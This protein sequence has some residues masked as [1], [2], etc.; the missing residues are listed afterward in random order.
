[1]TEPEPAPERLAYGTA[2]RDAIAAAGFNQKTFATK[3]ALISPSHLSMITTGRRLPTP[4]DAERFADLLGEHAAG[5]RASYDEASARPTPRFDANGLPVELVALLKTVRHYMDDLPMQLRG[6]KRLSLASLY[7]R[8]SV[9]MPVE[10]TVV[11]VREDSDEPGLVEEIRRSSILAEPF[12]EVFGRHDHLVIEGA[13][14]LGK[15]TLGRHLVAESINALLG[16][17]SDDPVIPLLLPARVL[18]P[19]VDITWAEALR[20]A[21]IR[22]YG[23]FAD[24]D[25]S[26][27]HFRAGVPGARWLIVVDALDEI[28]SFED[29]EKLL[30][31]IERRM[32]NADAERFVV[33]TRPLSPGETARLRAAGFYELQPF[34]R[35]A[36]EQFAQHWFNPGNT[37]DGALAAAEF[38][39]QIGAA[40][41]GEILVV[42]LLASIAAYVHELDRSRPLP[43]SRY[44]LYERYITKLAD[45]R[46]SQAASALTDLATALGGTDTA[47][48]LEE[49]RAALT[50]RMA[51]AYTARETSL[52]DVAR[53]FIADHGRTVP[54]DD[55]W[56]ELLAEWLSHTGLLG[57]QG[58]RLKFL[59][60][61]FAEHLAATAAARLLPE[62][63]DS[64]ESQFA[65][66]IHRLLADD[67]DAERILVH[68]LHRNS[69]DHA[70]LTH[71]QHGTRNQ[72]EAACRLLCHGVPSTSTHLDD[73]IRLAEQRIAAGAWDSDQVA[74]LS[75]L[76]RFEVVRDRLSRLVTESSID[77]EIKIVLI[78][79]L[80]ES[81]PEI[82]SGAPDLLRRW[83]DGRFYGNIRIKA[84]STLA[85]LGPGHR[86]AAADILEE[87]AESRTGFESA[88]RDAAEALAVLGHDCRERAA[89]VLL[90]VATD[91]TISSWTRHGA[92]VALSR[93]GPVHRERAA[94]LLSDQASD[95]T[96][97]IV[98]RRDSAAALAAFGGRYRTQACDLFTDI[99]GHTNAVQAALT[100]A[101]H[102]AVDPD[103]RPRAGD[104]LVGLAA[105]PN[106]RPDEV[107]SLG[108]ALVELGGEH[109]SQ[110]VGLLISVIN[111]PGIDEISHQDIV[112][113]LLNISRKHRSSVLDQLLDA[114]RQATTRTHIPDV[115]ART[116]ELLAVLSS[117]DRGL[118]AA[119][120][121]S[122][123][124]DPTLHVRGRRQSA[125]SLANLG[126]EHLAQV[127][128][129]L[130]R[131]LSTTASSRRDRV[132]AA[133]L[134]AVLDP[135]RTSL[136]VALIR[137]IGTDATTGVEDRETILWVLEDIVE[138][139]GTELAELVEQYAS[140][141]SVATESRLQPIQRLW[142]LGGVYQA[143]ALAIIDEAMSDPTTDMW[144]L[145][146][147]VDVLSGHADEERPELARSLLAKRCAT[148]DFLNFEELHS[149]VRMVERADSTR[150]LV[151]GLLTALLTEPL[152]ADFDRLQAAE[153]LATL[154]GDHVAS[155]AEALWQLTIDASTEIDLRQHALAVL[156]TLAPDRQAELAT[157][158]LGIAD[159]PNTILQERALSHAV[160]ASVVPEHETTAVEQLHAV[161]TDSQSTLAEQE[162]VVRVIAG[163]G[164]NYLD[165]AL[166][167]WICQL[168]SRPLTLEHRATLASSLAS[169]GYHHRARALQVLVEAVRH[170]DVHV[171]AKARFAQQLVNFRDP[172]R[173]A[174]LKALV[175]I[176][177]QHEV[178]AALRLHAGTALIAPATRQATQS[179]RDLASDRDIDA[180]ERVLA[181][182]SLSKLGQEAREAAITVLVSVMSDRVV[183]PWAR[184]RAAVALSTLGPRAR[185][186]LTEPLIAFTRERSEGDNAARL[187]A[188]GV[189]PELK[190]GLLHDATD[191]MATAAAGTG[192]STWERLHVAHAMLRMGRH[193]IGQAARALHT[194]ASDQQVRIWERRQ[195]LE[196]LG[197]LG[198]DNRLL[199]TELLRDMIATDRAD[200]WERVEVIAAFRYLGDDVERDATALLLALLDDAGTAPAERRH[201]AAT[202]LRLTD[203]ARVR[204]RSV[205]LGMASDHDAGSAERLSAAEALW[206][207]DGDEATMAALAVDPT[208][209]TLTR[210]AAAAALAGGR[211]GTRN[212]HHYLRIAVASLTALLSD[213]SQPADD[214]REGARLLGQLMPEH[215]PLA[216][217]VLDELSREQHDVLASAALA[218]WHRRDRGQIAADLRRASG[219]PEEIALAITRLDPVDRLH[220]IR[221]LRDLATGADSPSGRL[222]A[223]HN[224][225][226]ATWSSALRTTSIFV[227]DLPTRSP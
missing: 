36:L 53:A 98:G 28:P 136:A 34:D 135:A 72:R 99:A 88:R 84:A 156:I 157:R 207:Y 106:V 130:D 23:G 123:F 171:D 77:I 110:G 149:L 108:Y 210:G 18:A 26:A 21:T 112:K 81:C 73:C 58:A 62:T 168:E 115:R 7:V 222:R 177:G 42:P 32:S 100:L 138:A 144:S 200:T 213:E 9:T 87:I 209:T 220:G 165:H 226:V 89:V 141:R 192:L 83:A 184:Y 75:G 142:N 33:T 1:M 129:V 40:G 41:L 78:E 3:A 44:A 51:T 92:A 217:A 38:L 49:H 219:R 139:P 25:L 48:W 95:S 47:A 13:A 4:D 180:I 85:K 68:Y 111:D 197:T 124:S 201:A 31:A 113:K 29:R 54:Y 194:I 20:T 125:L 206:R 216:V 193:Q 147:F 154:G 70:L 152:M 186:E 153:A 166:D 176:A 143:T 97:T 103:L 11:R 160:V 66:L 71:L 19:L 203:E 27:S 185:A 104:V 107:L 140:D 76:I 225:A 198:R 60:Q 170:D 30:K 167:T 212:I 199:A 86:D 148:E 132:L 50:E 39:A 56:T 119:Q 59:H 109:R 127:M 64:Q 162:R 202:A 164:A 151:P 190:P 10:T 16:G 175:T 182:M 205:L 121:L 93:L 134:S 223:A 96:A 116:A 227:P 215:R 179:L 188:L 14:G 101:A 57:R 174:G 22:E 105:D 12:S 94:E 145:H 221:M 43:A 80:R 173:S 117:A 158:L 17:G 118:A 15:T 122:L 133:G 178:S 146:S 37:P 5:L 181:A 204:A 208:V 189:L 150:H 79:L 52:Y 191:Q 196:L 24:S 114:L 46:S 120:L 67:E 161:L 187:V 155:A 8:Q 224:L 65:A 91:R 195:A 211:S 61:T 45:A 2:L 82:R 6:R 183:D 63:F 131:M 55:Q 102:A 163:M 159:D 137:A 169:W 35:E 128:T 172:Y 90:A 126:D 218:A 74:K 214:R 69:A